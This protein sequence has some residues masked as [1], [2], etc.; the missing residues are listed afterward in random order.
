MIILCCHYLFLEFKVEND[1]TPEIIMTNGSMAVFFI[2]RIMQV[3]IVKQG[4]Y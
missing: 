3:G 4:I 1:T 2:W